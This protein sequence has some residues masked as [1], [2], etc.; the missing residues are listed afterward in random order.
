MPGSVA[1]QGATVTG[2]VA[3]VGMRGGASVRWDAVAG[4]TRYFVVRWNTGDA[5]CCKRISPPEAPGPTLSWQDELPKAGTYGY[6]VYATTPTGTYAGEVRLTF[7]PE[8]STSS[9]N[10]TL[11]G[12]GTIQQTTTSSTPTTVIASANPQPQPIIVQA[13]GPAELSAVTLAGNG[14]GILLTWSAVPNAVGYRVLRTVAGSG[15]P[16][17]PV[18]W[19]DRGPAAA[20][21]YVRGIDLDIVPGTSYSYWVEALFSGADASGPS[22]VSTVDSRVL[23]GSVSNLQASIGGTTSIVMP[24]PLSIR[25]AVPGSYV[26]WAWDPSPAIYRY[27]ISYEIVGGVEGFGA[28][29]ERAMVMTTGEPPGFPPV[30]RPVPQGKSVRFCVAL[31]PQGGD[32]AQPL[33]ESQAFGVVFGPVKC[34]TTQVP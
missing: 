9:G 32:P 19:L 27:E 4:A 17:S 25:G 8:A 16:A 5:T 28:V 31:L 20:P 3:E 22:P 14:W 11:A 29:V 34:L 7:T 26:T 23:I 10:V 21:G 12:S 1:A 2:I 33:A 6:R 13:A 30:V 15:T 24:G 18:G